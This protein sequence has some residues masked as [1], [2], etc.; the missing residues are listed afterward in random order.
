M[1][2]GP[3][4][5]RNVDVTTNSKRCPRRCHDGMTRPQVVDGGTAS[6]YGG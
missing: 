1:E 6:G 3:T 2:F 5:R 4:L